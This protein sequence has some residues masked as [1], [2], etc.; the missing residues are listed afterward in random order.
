M[1][2]VGYCISFFYMLIHYGFSGAGNGLGPLIDGYMFNC[3]SSLARR[4]EATIIEKKNC[5]RLF[6]MYVENYQQPH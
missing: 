6:M 1:L 3:S 4:F 2:K 5:G